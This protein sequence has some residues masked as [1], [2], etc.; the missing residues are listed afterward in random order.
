MHAYLAGIEPLKYGRLAG[1]DGYFFL[2]LLDN[3]AATSRFQSERMSQQKELEREFS[4]HRQTSNSLTAAKC[5][6]IDAESKIAQQDAVHRVADHNSY[7]YRTAAEARSEKTKAF[8]AIQKELLNIQISDCA[9]ERREVIM[10]AL[11]MNMVTWD[12]LSY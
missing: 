10:K 1:K 2:A 3:S 8:F 9:P 5:V 12:R 6:L 7:E 11:R 4:D